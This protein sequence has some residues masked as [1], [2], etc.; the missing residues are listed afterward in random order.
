[1]TFTRI[2]GGFAMSKPLGYRSSHGNGSIFILFAM[3]EVD[4]GKGNLFELEAP[5]L[6]G[7][8]LPPVKPL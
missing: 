2:V 4:R 1:M 6:P 7:E 5:W 8:R 3:P